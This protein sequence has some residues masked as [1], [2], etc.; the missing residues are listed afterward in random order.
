MWGSPSVDLQGEELLL[1][2][3]LRT[4]LIKRLKCV[5]SLQVKYFS[6]SVFFSSPLIFIQSNCIFHP[7]GLLEQLFEGKR[8]GKVKEVE[9][10]GSG[11]S[12][13]LPAS[14]TSEESRNVSR[15]RTH[16]CKV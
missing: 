7:R 8:W 16:Y 10:A 5:L 3:W 12:L 4:D 9:R 6:S 15:R 1:T 11:S 2:W 14:L 13:S